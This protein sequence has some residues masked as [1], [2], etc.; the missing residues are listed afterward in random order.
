M[1]I[2][3][4]I[5]LSG[6]SLTLS[7]GL[8][9]LAIL[10]VAAY[11][12][13]GAVRGAR[14]AVAAEQQ[15]LLQMEERLRDLLELEKHV[16]A[17]K[18]HVSVYLRL[19]PAEPEENVLLIV[20]HGAAHQAGVQSFQ[21]GLGKPV[22]RPGY[23][24]IPLTLSFEGSYQSTLQLL[25]ELRYGTRAIRVDKVNLATGGAGPS[26]LKVDIAAGAFYRSDG[27]AASSQ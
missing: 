9:A 8:L 18:Q 13:V 24:E 14:E 17:W 1:K 2:R 26:G 16:P 10:I 11:F 7:L 15:A 3:R 27:K 25:D 20:L 19:I 12:Q 22:A 21:V 6:P 5:R 4:T 23:I